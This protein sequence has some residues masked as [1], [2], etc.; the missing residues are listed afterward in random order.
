M[1]FDVPLWHV[2]CIGDIP[3]STVSA[4]FSSGTRR[5]VMRKSLLSPFVMLGAVFALVLAMIGG[6]AAVFSQSTP[7]ASP[8][9]SDVAMHPA[10]IHAGMCPEV[11]DVVFPLETVT[12]LDVE[13]DMATPAS[14][15][16]G[17]PEPDEVAT[18]AAVGTPVLTDTVM[19]M[20]STTV[21]EAP[22]DDILAA[23][24][25]INLHQ[26]P[27]NLAV[28]IACGDIVGEAENGELVIDLMEL[29][30]S[31][32][33]GQA[34]LTDNGDGTTTV[35]IA[36]RHVGVDAMGTPDATPKP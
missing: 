34:T 10:H 21:V 9:S 11:G 33:E 16:A 28:Y 35:E 23:E 31:G 20:G 30:D 15:N 24:H 18:E 6:S 25:A 26:S 19:P 5:F 4:A 14:P 3:E 2:I 36:V 12:Q 7:M 17:T 1:Q 22:L 32:V 27:E 29:N 13:T 8:A